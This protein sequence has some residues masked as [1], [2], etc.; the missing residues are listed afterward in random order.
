MSEHSH[1][2]R[3]TLIGFVAI[4]I[5]AVFPVMTQYTKGIPPFQ[6]IG[7]A[8][9]FMPLQAVVRTLW[10]KESL[11]QHFRMAPK[12]WLLGIYGLFGFH[13]FYFVALRVAPPIEAF[14]IDNLWPLL[15]VLL[16]APVNKEKLSPFHIVGC[17]LGFGGI[18]LIAQG[19]RFD[20]A[21]LLGYISAL[22]CALIWSSYS[23]YS[24]KWAHHIPR[25]ATS[26]FCGATALLSLLSHLFL[27][28][29]VDP[30]PVQWMVI[31]TMG[32]G[33]IGIAFFFWD[34]GVRFGDIRLLGVLCYLG[35]LIG[36]ILLVVFGFSEFTSRIGWATALILGGALLGSLADFRKKEG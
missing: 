8:F 13:F 24:K 29:W 36:A 12:I 1:R 26:A 2:L 34:M 15:M 17:L 25:D 21:H 30:T 32:V 35:T 11:R 27:E 19:A 33:P 31:L 20:S 14:L 9:L 22:A 4:L 23:V 18:V 5:W 16:A 28:T 10:K 7:L 3:A 6:L